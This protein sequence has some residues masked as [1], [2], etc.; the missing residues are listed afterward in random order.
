M[1]NVGNN[2]GKDYTIIPIGLQFIFFRLKDELKIEVCINDWMDILC[3]HKTSFNRSSLDI[4]GYYLEL[5]NVTAEHYKQCVVTGE[6]INVNKK[7]EY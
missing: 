6:T 3:P 5:Y 4:A 1:T 2:T 7:Y